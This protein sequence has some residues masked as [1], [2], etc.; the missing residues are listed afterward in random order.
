MSG[1]DDPFLV[2]MDQQ[3]GGV[4]ALV[5]P[6]RVAC[7]YVGCD[8]TFSKVCLTP[9]FSSVFMFLSSSASI[10]VSFFG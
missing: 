8:K 7:T 3:Y 4:A 5:L 9:F 2:A 6:S 1:D 10:V